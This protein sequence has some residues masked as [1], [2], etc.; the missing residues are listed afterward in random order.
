MP[1]H[2][3]ILFMFSTHIVCICT[4]LLKKKHLH[5][6]FLKILINTRMRS[7]T[8]TVFHILLI[9][10]SLNKMLF[11]FLYIQFGSSFLT[12][13][14]IN[15]FVFMQINS[16]KQLKAQ[17]TTKKKC[18]VFF[19]QKRNLIFQSPFYCAIITTFL[20]R[21]YCCKVKIYLLLRLFNSIK[22]IVI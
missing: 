9:N 16:L 2:L 11:K 6:I 1:L 21:Y 3:V 13:Y 18:M 8:F 5:C 15:F 10:F 17:T 20:S 12:I 19:P 4:R 14:S 22:I 7:Y